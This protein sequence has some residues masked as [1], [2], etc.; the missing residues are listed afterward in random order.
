M[1]VNAH[2]WPARRADARRLHAPPL[3][4]EAAAGAPG[5]AGRAAAAAARRRCSTL[6]A[7]DD[8][9]SRLV[10]P[11]RRWRCATGRCRARAAA[12]D[13]A[14]WTLLVQ[15]VDLHLP[16]AADAGAPFASCPTR[17]GRPDG[18]LGQPGGGVGPHID[19]YDVFLIQ[20]HGKRRWRVG[21]V[22]DPSVGRGCPLK[23]L[24][25][26]EPS[27]DWVL[28]PGDMLYLPPRWGHDGMAEGDCMTCSVGFRTWRRQFAHVVHCRTNNDLEAGQMPT[29]LLA[30]GLLSV[31]LFD[32]VHYRGIA[33]RETADAVQWREAIDAVLQRSEEAFPATTL[34][35]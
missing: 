33:S 30:P 4:E 27:D 16:A 5:L 14:G 26:F 25:H 1:D 2:R 34:G 18:L 29:I 23:I 3:A 31:R 13:A 35:L 10:A 17:G 7:R 28:E 6:A 21:R 32:R 20:V 9:E 19:D 24:Q 11:G 22:A 8:V 15:G 12:A